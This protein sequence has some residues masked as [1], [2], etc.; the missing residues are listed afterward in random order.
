MQLVLLLFQV[1]YK[2][3]VMFFYNQVYGFLYLQSRPIKDFLGYFEVW[4]FLFFLS[5]KKARYMYNTR[6]WH[7]VHNATHY[8][9]F[10]KCVKLIMFC[11][12]CINCVVNNYNTLIEWYKCSA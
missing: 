12:N 6:E 5:N 4:T 11:R 1:P 9:L 3:E 10:C 2:Q 8:N 7:M